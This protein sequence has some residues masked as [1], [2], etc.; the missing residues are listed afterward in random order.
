MRGVGDERQR[1]ERDAGGELDEEERPVRHQGELQRPDA[2][3][4]RCLGAVGRRSVRVMVVRHP[5]TVLSLLHVRELQDAAVH[6]LGLV[7]VQ[8]VAA[9]RDDLEL[10]AGGG[11]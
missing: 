9:R 8:E 7:E 3:P 4:M 6:G 11:R 10:E 5:Q 1:A 2:G